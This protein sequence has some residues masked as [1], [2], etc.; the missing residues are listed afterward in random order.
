MIE[1]LVEIE[2]VKDFEEQGFF[3]KSFLGLDKRLDRKVAVKDINAANISSKEDLESYFEE[4]LKLSQSHHPRILPVYYA[5]VDN[6]KKVG[7]FGTPRIVTK[8]LA[9]GSLNKYLEACFLDKKTACIGDLIRFSHDIIQGM[10]HLHA[11]GVLH[12]DLKASN[13]FIGD[14]NK[15]VIADF[16]QS[17]MIKDELVVKAGNLYPVL[18]PPECVSKRVVDKTADIYQFGILL[19][20]IFNYDKYRTLLDEIYK[21]N[22]SVVSE[23][24]KDGTTKDEKKLEEFK[25]NMKRLTSDIKAGKFPNKDDHHYFVPKEVREIVKKCTNLKVEDRYNTFY[26]IQQ[27]LN[28]IDLKS[29][30]DTLYQ[31]LETKKLHFEKDGKPC[32]IEV[33]ENNNKFDILPFKNGRRLESQQLNN[34]SKGYFSRNLYNLVN[35]I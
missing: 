25:Q 11:L 4:A 13:V 18:M 2:H 3:S 34:I 9:K 21:L 23:L 32:I 33:S 27:D 29:E 1:T 31:C 6:S 26:E 28:S 12:L 5:G 7:S 19:Y 24:F 22:T 10:I 20:S 17:K 14:D 16:G 15:L 30:A 8:F 35:E